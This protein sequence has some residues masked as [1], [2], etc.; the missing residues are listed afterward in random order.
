[1]AGFGSSW[2]LPL[3]EHLV[4]RLSLHAEVVRGLF[5]SHIYALLYVSPSPVESRARNAR[6]ARRHANAN[7]K[8]WFDRQMP[9]F[10]KLKNG[11]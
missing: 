10:E 4:N 2:N 3:F 5:D 11:R 7:L 1:M 6:L 9:V 8:G